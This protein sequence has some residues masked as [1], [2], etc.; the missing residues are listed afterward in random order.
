[1]A[2]RAASDDARTNPQPLSEATAPYVATPFVPDAEANG[3]RTIVQQLADYV[4]RHAQKAAPLAAG[5][6]LIRPLGEGTFGTVWLAEDRSGVKVAIKFFAHG[7]GH[8]WQQLQD[9]VRSLAQLDTTHG[10]IPLKEVEPD[11]D[12]PYF[13]MSY[14]EGG[15]LAQKLEAGP[16]PAKQAIRF[17]RAIAEALAFVHEKGIRHCDLKPGN[18]LINQ[19]GQPLIADFGQAHL[20]DDATPSLGTFFYMAPEQAEADSQIP[21]TR[22]DVYGLGALCYAM[23]TGQPPRKDTSL[24]EELKQTAHLHHRLKI[25]RDRIRAMPEPKAHHSVP[26]VDRMM[27]SIIDRC[28][29]LNPADRPRDAGAVLAALEVRKRQQRQRPLLALAA[30]ASVAA[31]LLLAGGGA[32]IALSAAADAANGLRESQLQNNL[33]TAQL[34]ANVL[35]EKLDDRVKTLTALASPSTAPN[36]PALIETASIARKK[37]AETDVVVPPEM[38]PLRRWLLD[39]FNGGASRYFLALVL[40]DPEG[41]VLARA[42]RIESTGPPRVAPAT[43]EERR[44][45]FDRSYAWR[46]WFNGVRDFYDEQDRPRPP[47]RQPHISQPYVGKYFTRGRQLVNVVVPVPHGDGIAGLLMGNVEWDEYQRWLT[48]V[49]IPG[50]FAVVV[51]DL[52]QCL[53]H[54]DADRVRPKVN[55][56]APAYYADAAIP[57]DRRSALADFRDPVAGGTYLAAAAPFRPIH[58]RP[59]IVWLAMIEHDPAIALAPVTELQGRLWRVGLSCLAIMAL[60]IGGMWS[61]LLWALRRE[62]RLAHG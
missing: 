41:F 58:S 50:G 2:D 6:T 37:S 18:I 16:L 4:A 38:E 9:E 20:S 40:I 5:Y 32:W 36:L 35:E 44:D 19:H 28:L 51:N 43:L 24:S 31:L 47:V 25:Y 42:G 30:A 34:A 29:S 17:F 3:E 8:R 14:A 62:E 12:P 54:K 10:I 22:W 53:C 48:D 15:S 49:P 45:Q 33:L 11:A 59:E 26:G 52:G 39:Q 13:V 61:G 46:N 1:M 56:I 60:V 57:R 55:E 27:A 23:L 21:D 7:A